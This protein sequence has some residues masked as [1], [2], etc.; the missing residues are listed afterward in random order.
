MINYKPR[1]NNYLLNFEILKFPE[2]VVIGSLN[3]YASFLTGDIKK[4][5]D[6]IRLNVDYT[7]VSLP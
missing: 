6:K 1:R 2:I 4:K 5:T 7:N 3:S